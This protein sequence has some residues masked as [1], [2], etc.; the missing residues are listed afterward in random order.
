[1]HK[2]TF[3]KNFSNLF[4]PKV[5]SLLFLG[6][7][8]GVPILLIFLMQMLMDLDKQKPELTLRFI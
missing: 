5:I 8:A 3:Y 6:F 2:T 7:S 4:H 1:M